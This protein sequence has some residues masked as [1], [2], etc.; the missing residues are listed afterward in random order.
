MIDVELNRFLDYLTNSKKS[1][2]AKTYRSSLSSFVSW[3]EERNKTLSTFTTADADEF[4]CN[5]ENQNTAN[6]FLAALKSFMSHRFRSMSVEDP[7]F[8]I[9]NQRYL[10][11]DYIKTRKKRMNRGKVA[12]TPSE[13][14]E[15]LEE[16]KRHKRSEVL[17][18]GTALV[19]L[20]GAR[21]M[22]QEHFMRASGIQHPA[23]YRWDKN[24]MMLWTSKVDYMRFLAWNEKFTPYV[25]TW[26][27][28]LPFTTPGEYLTTHLNKY[29]IGG[30]N[31][32]ARTGRK[33]VQTNLV[34]SGVEGWIVDE[35]L[36]HS[37]KN[38]I[39]DTYTDFSMHEARIKDV[40]MNKHYMNEIV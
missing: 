7:R 9:E 18:A 4:F 39:S 37:N 36:G 10:Q 1:P 23:E 13:I 32:T 3:L 5:I 14:S 17:Y 19:F 22:E 40:F 28:S 20:W 29:T 38:S 15:L 27:K 8:P 26:V 25:K 31:P 30:I 34:M 33:S 24:E 12:L 21:S 11:L 35:I 2:A 6:M 16:I